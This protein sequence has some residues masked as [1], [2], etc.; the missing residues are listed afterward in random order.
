M[1]QFI[2]KII[3]IVVI[4]AVV[5]GCSQ[6]SSET[7]LAERLVP[8]ESN[9]LSSA[10]GEERDVASISQ[11]ET[12]VAESTAISFREKVLM[13]SDVPVVALDK[14]IAYYDK[15]QSIIR[16]KKFMTIFDIGQHSGKR[17]FYM[18]DLIT[19][20]VKAMHVAHG[21]GSD[22]NHDGVATSFSNISGSNMSS[23]GFMLTAEE[24]V[25][26]HGGSMRLDGQESRN[27]KVRPR[28]IVVHS[29][30]Y[31]DPKLSKMGRSQGCPA[32]SIANIKEVVAN[33]KNGSLF[34]IFHKDHE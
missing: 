21:N 8:A 25:G 30:S 12:V 3:L 11:D 27:S 34:Y 14:A 6:P 31:V 33:L 16:N 7:S 29:A 19:G 26:K 22:S 23:L 2:Q 24:Y 18:I 13:N 28:A 9:E 17:R 1:L 32:V 4:S 15:N 5:V 10:E 20:N